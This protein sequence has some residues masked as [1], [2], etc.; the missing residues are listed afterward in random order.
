M[1]FDSDEWV[2]VLSELEDHHSIFARFWLVGTIIVD[3]SVPTAGISFDEFG[4][5]IQFIINPDFWNTLS[6]RE[7]AF[8]IAHECLHAYFEHGGRGKGLDPEL[9]N[10]AMDLI[11][12]HGLVDQFG[13]DRELDLKSWKDFMWHETVF[14]D[15]HES[16]PRGEPM[17][18][19]YAK[20]KEM[21][22][23]ADQEGRP[24]P[25]D[26]VS[27]VDDHSQMGGVPQSIIQD[28]LDGLSTEELKDF[29]DKIAQTDNTE[30]PGNPKAKCNTPG[31]MAGDMAIKIALEKVKKL[32]TWEDTVKDV[33]GRFMGKEKD[34]TREQWAKD[35]R[36]NADIIHSDSDLMLPSDLDETIRVRDKVLVYCYQDTS[37]SCRDLTKRFAKAIKSIPEDKFKVVTFGFDTKVYPINMQNPVFKGFGGTA[38]DIIERHIQSEIKNGKLSKYPDV[39]F[40]VT[41]G[42]GNNVKPEYPD[43]WHV[44]LEPG[45]WSDSKL[46]T[47]CFPDTCKFYNIKKFEQAEVEKAKYA[48]YDA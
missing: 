4:N 7:K 16:I 18:Y 26:G 45:Y 30:S 1:Q 46:E 9:A 13:F 43:R 41:D 44:F 24:G 48:K 10:I 20:L 35:A 14:P 15:D 25:G 32:K 31:T 17:E 21:Q 2:D 42:Y 38:F 47:Y 5:G 12:N 22:K 29:Q 28:I 40:V 37:G 36:R 39:V 8:V 23:K 19:Y 34:I 27:T 11:V 33:L 3:K 6:L